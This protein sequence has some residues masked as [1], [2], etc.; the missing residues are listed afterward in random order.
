MRKHLGATIIIGAIA[1]LFGGLIAGPVVGLLVFVIAVSA[2][3]HR[4][5]SEE[6]DAL[7]KSTECIDCGLPA[8]IHHCEKC[9]D[10]HQQIDNTIPSKVS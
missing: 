1:G 10:S 5:I 8:N 2:I 3:E 4:S 6:L 7:K 9:T